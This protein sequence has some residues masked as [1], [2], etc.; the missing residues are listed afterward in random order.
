[1]P[2]LTG[3]DLLEAICLGAHN[4]NAHF[5]AT[6]L[7]KGGGVDARCAEQEGATL[8]MTAGVGGHEAVVRMLLQRG[9][10][11]DLPNPDDG[12]TALMNA[13]ADGHTMIV[14]A[15]LDAKANVSLQTTDSST[16]LMWAEQQEHTATAQ[17]LRQHAK[18]LIAEVRVAASAV[19]TAAAADAMAAELLGEAEAEKEEAAKTGKSNKSKAK[20]APSTATGEPGAVASVTSKPR[21]AAAD[22]GCRLTCLMRRTRAMRR[23]WLR[24]WTRAAAWMQAAK[25]AK[26]GRC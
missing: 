17:L 13:A 23:P 8:L 7:D 21:L 18:R 25:S 12:G 14:Q 24:G 22:E 1:M 5:V 3:E 20:T 15:L 6:W 4:G 2:A 26:A 19:H 9:A 10:S 16:A 11:V